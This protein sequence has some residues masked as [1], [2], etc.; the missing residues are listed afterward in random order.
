ME[1]HRVVH[2]KKLKRHYS[3][4]HR[5]INKI[6]ATL[7]NAFV[8]DVVVYVC[9]SFNILSN[10]DVWIRG[11]A[12]SSFCNP[13]K[14]ATLHPH[15]VYTAIGQVWSGVGLNF[16]FFLFAS[17]LWPH[18][19]TVFPHPKREVFQNGLQRD[20]SLYRGNWTF[21]ELR[22]KLSSAD[23]GLWSSNL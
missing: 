7:T 13:L 12:S 8:C 3:T 5:Q 20:F 18:W 16:S 4:L 22:H 19:N 21:V 11:A 6:D 17:A 14:Q 23:R 2:A 1:N 10:T 15:P 9:D